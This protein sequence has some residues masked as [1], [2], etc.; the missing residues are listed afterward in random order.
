[1]IRRMVRGGQNVRVTMA[2]RSGAIQL[3]GMVP[4]AA[5][6]QRAEAIAKS[7]A[8]EAREVINELTLL[9]GIQVNLRVRVAEI[10]RDVTRDLGFNWL[11][12]FNDGTW[13]LGLRTGS[14]VGTALAGLTGGV[15]G[16]ALPGSR[17]GWRPVPAPAPAAPMACATTAAISTSTG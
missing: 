3:T 13:Q 2:G 6:A 7:M 4:T 8:G 5:D 9:S 16:A 17:G 15:A 14:V 10:S 12:A 11:G 1:M